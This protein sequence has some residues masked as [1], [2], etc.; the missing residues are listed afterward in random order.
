MKK[1]AMISDGVVINVVE[2][3][4]DGTWDPVAAGAIPC[5]DNVSVGWLYDGEVFTDPNALSQAE[6]YDQALNDINSKYVSEK[7]ILSSAYINACLFNGDSEE[8]KKAEVLQRLAALNQK[9]ESDLN[10]LDQSY[11]V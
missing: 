8:Q 6:L 4:E 10:S 7:S 2:W 1:Y 3:D 9:Y 5:P 11:G